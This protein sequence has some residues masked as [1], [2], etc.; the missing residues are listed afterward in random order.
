M[1]PVLSNIKTPNGENISYTYNTNNGFAW[2]SSVSNGVGTWN[3]GILLNQGA[4]YSNVV[5]ITDPNGNK[6]VVTSDQFDHVLSDADALGNT[7]TYGYDSYFRVN[8]ITNPQG[9]YVQYQY[10]ARGNV[11]QAT[12][13]PSS[14]S[15]TIV[16]SAS[17]DTTCTYAAKCNKPN[18]VTDERG[19]TTTY[20]YNYST[21][22]VTN[23]TRPAVNGVSPQT[24]Y[25]YSLLYAWYKGP[26]GSLGQGSAP[27]SMLTMISKCQ[28]TGSCSGTS[29]EAR[30]TLTYG[31]SG[32][33]NN[34][35][36]TQV[37]SGA[38]DGSLT[39]TTSTTY[40]VFGNVS[41]V[42]GPLGSAQTTQFWYDADR[43][44]VGA[45]GPDPDGSGPLLNRARVVTYNADGQVTEVQQGTTSGYTNPTVSGFTSLAQQLTSYD[46]AARKVQDAVTAGG[47]NWSVVQYGYD[48]ANRLQCTAVRMNPAAFSSLPASACSLGPAGTFGNDRITYN[49]YDAANRL[50]QVTTAYGDA[51]QRNEKTVTYT[52][53]GLPQT[54]TDADG[55]VSTYDYDGFDRLVELQYPNPSGGGSSSS[56]YEQ[57]T[58]DAA[59]NI[60]QLR[61][62]DGQ[63]INLTY[64]VLGRVATKTPPESANAVTYTYDNLS[65]LT[66][67]A[68]ASQSIAYSY[69]ALGRQLTEVE[70]IGTM[71]STYDL[72]GRRTQ[73]K[74]PDGFY[75]NYDYDLLGETLDARENGATS[76]VGVLASYTYDNLGNIT[77][78]ARGNGVS[79]SMGYDADSHLASLTYSGSSNN[80]SFTGYAYNPAGQL[81]S[82][83]ASNDA[84]AWN[85]GANLSQAYGINGQNQYTSVG[86][87]AYGYDGRGNLGSG[88]A[89]TYTYDSENRLITASGSP[90]ATLSYDP[91]GR[92]FQ[93]AASATTQFLYDGDEIVAEYS[94]G[95]V[96]RRYVDGP[97][98]DDPLV[99]YEG[100]GTADRRWLLKDERGSVIAETNPSGSVLNIDSYDEYG[101]SGSSNRGRFQYTGQAWI[102][103]AGAYDYK[104]RVY[105]PAIGRF[106]QT[107]P[108]GYGAGMN[109]YAYADVDPIDGIDPTGL[110]NCAGKVD[111]HADGSG[112]PA[113]TDQ[114]CCDPSDSNCV[115][116]QG[117]RS[118]HVFAT[119]VTV[120]SASVGQGSTA[121]AGPQ[122]QDLV[123]RG[124]RKPS[125]CK[126]SGSIASKIAT[127]AGNV[128]N[129][130]SGAALAFLGAAAVT[131]ETGVGGIG[132]GTAA[133]LSEGLSLGASFV[134][135]V[136]QYYDK[137]FSGMRAT[138]A[139][140]VLTLALGPLGNRMAA[141]SKV[142]ADV[143]AMKLL[144]NAHATPFELGLSNSCL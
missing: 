64:D 138:A 60:T 67:A 31:S 2:V 54:V 4:N 89:Q 35:L 104:A 121:S 78:I 112:G 124:K 93:T 122:T 5:T 50:T 47:T 42:Q 52:N 128:S 73:L 71:T 72:A 7:T 15:G 56:D 26:S 9:G 127:V 51:Q 85:A 13:Y 27:V 17:Y 90:T 76:G 30:T 75:V 18:S 8:Q 16:T 46:S 96:L 110:Y 83:S 20:T 134:Q 69:D 57:Y 139:G 142:A 107:D 38:G 70:P 108:S 74:W 62:R 131:S 49:T 14:G 123:V 3:Y 102:P 41:T 98:V 84:Y 88:T 61:Q 37:S 116:V 115:D 133:G 113:T 45:V 141:A 22:Q 34:L 144:F 23:E 11:I 143:P 136:A 95:T 135:G 91:A 55:N 58:L 140:G 87:T 44:L 59:G 97:V 65:R 68:T 117:Q 99:W 29:D 81:M 132:F 25:T 32:V 66:K 109:L 118:P 1:G 94:S 63:L 24:N 21:G 101:Q 106:L 120:F 82:R 79:S 126:G 125:G 40:D 12:R 103:E 48:M 86:G 100:S 129:V 19:N 43:E 10:D 6:R 53:D 105:L 114:A 77:A 36:P 28:T 92:L 137:N 119:N 39:A 130:S 111:T 33:A 80:Q